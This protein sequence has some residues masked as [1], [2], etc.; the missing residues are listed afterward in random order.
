MIRL[1]PAIRSKKPISGKLT[2]LRIVLRTSAN[3]PLTSE[4]FCVAQQILL[5]VRV[6]VLQILTTSM[7][8][9]WQR[10]ER[11]RTLKS[12]SKTVVDVNGE[13]FPYRI[14]QRIGQKTCIFPWADLFAGFHSDLGRYRATRR[15]GTPHY[16]EPQRRTHAELPAPPIRPRPS[17]CHRGKLLLRQSLTQ[18]CHQW[19][20]QGPSVLP[21]CARPEKVIGKLHAL[22]RLNKTPPLPLPRLSSLPHLSLSPNAKTIQ[23]NPHHGRHRHRP[24]PQRL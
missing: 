1:L 3:L 24:L 8:G 21:T 5:F 13:L 23:Q 6:W 9:T 2:N 4:G 18:C 7:R 22:S 17:P 12:I 20:S 16:G 19:Q 15:S 14:T 11:Y 10:R